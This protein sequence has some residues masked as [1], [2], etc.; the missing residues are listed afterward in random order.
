M[1]EATGYKTVS[2]LC[3]PI[4]VKNRVIGVV[5]MVNKRDD[6]SFAH[7]DEVHFGLFSTF[8]GLALH[9]A[10]LYDRIMRKEQKYR[11]AL[12]VLSYHNTCKEFEVAEMLMD[13]NPIM[14][15]LI[16]YYLD[17]Y[18]IDEFRKCKYVITMFRSLFT[19]D[20][21]EVSTLTRFVLTV[22]KNYRN[23]PYHNFD[24][25]WT[26]AHSM[27]V[28]L[29]HDIQNRFDFKMVRNHLLSIFRCNVF[30]YSHQKTKYID[31]HV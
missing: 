24:H 11:V 4:K 26:V 3:M 13:Q 14:V 28:M 29:K 30:L 22:K 12:E 5:Q 27:F 19:L 23:V 7:E 1:D 10:R 17:P 18:K 31:S 15:D 21:F 2:I 9:H 16:D 6:I 25:G 20:N 8:F